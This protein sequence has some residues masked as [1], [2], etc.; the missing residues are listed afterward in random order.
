MIRSPA[1]LDEVLTHPTP[2]LIDEAASWSDP[3]VVLGA[4]GKMGPTL[5]VL[6][7]RAAEAAGRSLD[8]VA[9]SRFS[10]GAAKGWLE[11]RGVRTVSCDILDREAVSRLPDSTNVVYLVGMKFGTSHQPGPTWALNTLAPAVAIERYAGARIVALSTGNVYPLVDVRS[12]GAD[13]DTPLAPVGEYANACLGRERIYRYASERFATPVASIR[14]N[15]A[16]ELRYGV[17]V[18]L[19]HRILRGEPIDL[20]MGHVNLIWQRDA[21]DRILRSF[22]LAGVPAVPVNLTGIEILSVRSLAARLAAQMG[23]PVSFTG[24]EAPTALLND[25]RR[26]AARLGEPE[27]SIDTILEWTAQWIRAGGH[28]LGK[29]TRFEIRDGTY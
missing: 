3:L 16:V 1:E 8:V 2:V 27:T 13:E 20:A 29:P 10:D 28:S 21:N 26:L 24:E 23:V 5:C 7:A 9:V 11:A 15:Y 19:A 14:L 6:A 12:R 18:D 25:A 17:L 4:G 22:P